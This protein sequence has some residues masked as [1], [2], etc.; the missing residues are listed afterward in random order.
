MRQKSIISFSKKYI[1]TCIF[2]K[3]ILARH[4]TILYAINVIARITS[5]FITREHH[6]TFIYTVSMS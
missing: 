5:L 6:A 4:L 2:K 1:Y 3:L